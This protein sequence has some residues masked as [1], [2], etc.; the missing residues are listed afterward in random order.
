MDYPIH[1]SITFSKRDIDFKKAIKTVL[2]NIP[3]NKAKYHNTGKGVNTFDC[4]FKDTDSLRPLLNDV[5]RHT[6]MYN[7][8]LMGPEKRVFNNDLLSKAN[9]VLSERGI[10]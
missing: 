9:D 4:Y 1:F 2:N 6:E 7:L 8:H 3:K 10:S 5:L